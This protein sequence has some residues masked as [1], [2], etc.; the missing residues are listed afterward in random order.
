MVYSL[1]SLQAAGNV[2]TR[3]ATVAPD[4]ANE[5]DDSDTDD[6]ADDD[7]NRSVFVY[8]CFWLSKKI[9]LNGCKCLRDFYSYSMYGMG[10][11]RA[12]PCNVDR[13]A[14]QT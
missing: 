11:Q 6:E 2:D 1:I 3:T 13:N 10:T 8:I 12:F 5:D 9:T 4:G 7:F 14:F